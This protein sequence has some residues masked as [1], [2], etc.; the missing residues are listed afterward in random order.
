MNLLKNQKKMFKNYIRFAGG[1]SDIYFQ[2]SRWQGQTD[3]FEFS[4]NHSTELV[5]GELVNSDSKKQ[6]NKQK[7]HFCLV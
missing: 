2:H 3:L 6:T 4:D 7:L 1:G 5:T